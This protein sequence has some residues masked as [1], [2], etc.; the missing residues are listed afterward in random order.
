MPSPAD[1]EEHLRVIRSLMERSTTY[2]TLSAQ[3]ALVGGGLA[4]GAGLWMAWRASHGQ[5]CDKCELTVWMVVLAITTLANFTF[6]WRDDRRS[7][8]PFFSARARWALRALAPSFILAGLVTLPLMV[9]SLY[10]MG[11]AWSAAYALG[12]LAASH[13][14][15]R[16]ILLLGRAFF[17]A[18]VLG[19]IPPL[20]A[21]SAGANVPGNTYFELYMA[22][23]FGLFH[24]LYAAFTW[25][26]AAGATA[27]V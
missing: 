14:A 15:P 27:D 22:A 11:L 13:F 8:E 4:L 7:G 21:P 18:T 17:V 26:R 1:A 5:A 23:T 19:M 6:L 25:P 20:I 24:L 10:F 16:S 9:V 3:G 12:L 2:R